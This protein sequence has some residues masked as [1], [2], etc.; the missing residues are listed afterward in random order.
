MTKYVKCAY[1]TCHF[2]NVSLKE[3]K[4]LFCFFHKIGFGDLWKYLP[5][6]AFVGVSF[7]NPTIYSIPEICWSVYFITN[8]VFKTGW[9]LQMKTNWYFQAAYSFLVGV[10]WYV[11][12]CVTTWMEVLNMG[13]F[14]SS[15]ARKTMHLCLQIHEILHN[16]NV[17]KIFAA[18]LSYTSPCWR[19]FLCI[20]LYNLH[21]LNHAMAYISIC[22][23]LISLQTT[24]ED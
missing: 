15:Q 19:Y 2:F 6:H 8:L 17:K 24:M 14:V 16:S 1:S 10:K 12:N 13:R 9:I 22:W 5:D 20:L 11:H 21:T 4:K 23:A 7:T 3:K 18:Y